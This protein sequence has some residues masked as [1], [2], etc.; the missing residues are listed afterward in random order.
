MK[1][2]LWL[3][4]PLAVGACAAVAPVADPKD[5]EQ[6]EDV[7]LA[8]FAT[9]RTVVADV[10]ELVMTANFYR[11]VTST[12]IVTAVQQEERR[13][14][15]DGGTEFIYTNRAPG[16]D[17]ALRFTIGS[18]R[19]GILERAALVV[20]G[21]RHELTLRAVATGQVTV[22]EGATTNDF[23]RVAIEDGVYRCTR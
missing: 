22:R 17:P 21:G 1:R 7:F 8:P 4:G 10:L 23:G 20:L 5:V 2:N 16:G 14:R 12:G 18:T 13:P 9:E 19:F 15:Q 11:H 6:R 3:F